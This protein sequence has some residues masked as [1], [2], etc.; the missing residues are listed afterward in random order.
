MEIMKNEN[1]VL[2]EKPE[3]KASEGLYDNVGFSE[4]EITELERLNPNNDLEIARQH[5]EMMKEGEADEKAVAD[6]YEQSGLSVDQIE[7]LKA[8]NPKDDPRIAT[9]QISAMKFIKN[10]DNSQADYFAKNMGVKK[11]S[12]PFVK[13]KKTFTK[14]FRN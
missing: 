11:G 3:G 2:T 10:I 7:D 6:I 14:F 9:E 4:G 1:E 12:S 5:I 8:L 13:I